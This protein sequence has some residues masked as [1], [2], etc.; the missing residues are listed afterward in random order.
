MLKMQRPARRIRKTDWYPHKNYL[1]FDVPLTRPQATALVTNPD[2]VKRHSFLPLMAF[3]KR[4]RR[5]KRKKNKPPSITWKTRN[6]A[7][8]SNRDACIFSYYA[9]ILTEPYERLI[10]LLGIDD[11]VI[12]YRK[13]GSNIDLALA[14]FA[15]IKTRGSCVAFA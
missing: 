11:V 7:Y 1:H 4:E 8:C 13:L 5:Y 10:K 12:G 14:A 9:H 6:L 2:A 3:D 15:E